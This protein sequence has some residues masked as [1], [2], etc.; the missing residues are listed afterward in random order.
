MIRLRIADE[1]PHIYVR[2]SGTLTEAEIRKELAALPDYLDAAPPGFV[3]L[4]EYPDLLLIEPDAVGPLFYYIARIFEA[5][6][7]L[8]VF[9]T[10]GKERHPG[11]RAF[12]SQIDTHGSLRVVHTRAEADRII[13]EYVGDGG[14][15]TAGS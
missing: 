3:L 10:G 7:G 4:A 2:G 6:P 1:A 5:Q 12:M 9:T 15:L 11:L 13:D 8:A 14:D